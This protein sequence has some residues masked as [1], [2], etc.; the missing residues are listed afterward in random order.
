M[1]V[2]LIVEDDDDVRDIL[3]ETVQTFGHR[4]MTARGGD[5]ALA[6]FRGGDRMVPDLLITDAMM[7]LMNGFD[8]A[9]RACAMRPNLAVIYLTGGDGET[10]AKDH[11]QLAGEIVLKPIMPAALCNKIDKALAK[12]H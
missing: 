6:V 5:A 9:R 4:V 10:I 11:G 7:P 1:A 3:A 8:L 2:V 12:Q